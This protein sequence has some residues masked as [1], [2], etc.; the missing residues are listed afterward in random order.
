MSLG[1]L[2]LNSKACMASHK[3]IKIQTSPSLDVFIKEVGF[4]QAAAYSGEIERFSRPNIF[5]NFGSCIEFVESFVEKLLVFIKTS[6][7][8]REVLFKRIQY[9]KFN[10]QRLRRFG[11]QRCQQFGCI[12]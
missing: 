2:L 8:S 12:N 7:S 5:S 6:T 10:V 1:L 11:P 4:V 3:K 9:E